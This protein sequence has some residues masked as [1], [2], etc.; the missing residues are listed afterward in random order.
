[1]EQ[2]E[3]ESPLGWQQ[4]IP[5]EIGQTII[6]EESPLRYASR[7]ER[8]RYL[9]RNFWFLLIGKPHEVMETRNYIYMCESKGTSSP[10]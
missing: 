5:Y 10:S 3:A 8:L 1:M 6:R 9:T 2:E 4:G 7:K